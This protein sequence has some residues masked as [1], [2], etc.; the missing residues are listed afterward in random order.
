MALLL[1]K[2]LGDEARHTLVRILRDRILSAPRGALGIRMETIGMGIGGGAAGDGVRITGLVPGMPAG[3]VLQVGDIVRSVNDTPLRTNNDLTNA[4]QAIPPGGEVKLVVRRVKRDAAGK[5]VPA[6]PAL[7]PAAVPEAQQAR[8][9]IEVSV[10]LGSTDDLA[11]KGDPQLA[12]GVLGGGV[13]IGLQINAERSATAQFFTEQLNAQLHL[14][15]D[16]ELADQFNPLVTFVKR[17]EAAYKRAEAEGAPRATLPNFSGVN[18]PPAGAAAP[19]PRMLS[20]TVAKASG[21][22]GGMVQPVRCSRVTRG[23]VS[24]VSATAP[25][26]VTTTGVPM[27]CA[28]TAERPNASGSVE[29]TAR[30]ADAASAAGISV[31]WPTR[32]TMPVRPAFSIAASNSRT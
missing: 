12:P 21:S 26:S 7:A 8:D 17:A 9:E 20:R 23:G 24:T 32:V 30:T 2:D 31:T 16:E 18:P 28:S 13:A 4:V 11:E 27:A 15:V 14:F 6:V 10:R 25:R 3:R 19:M 5:A 29:V 22:L 1:R